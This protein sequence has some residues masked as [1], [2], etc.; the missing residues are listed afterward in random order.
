[1]GLPKF[2]D[3]LAALPATR[4]IEVEMS[5]QFPDSD[6]NEPRCLGQLLDAGKGISRWGD[7]TFQLTDSFIQRLQWRSFSPQT[8]KVRRAPQANL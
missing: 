7:L 2:G 8:Q 6:P 1:M 3:L 4:V 5:L